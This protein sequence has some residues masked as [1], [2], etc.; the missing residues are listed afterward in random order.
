MKSLIAVAFVGVLMA[1]GFALF[2]LLRD[3]GKTNRTVYAL[4][5]RVALSVALLVFIWVSWHFGW[6]QPTQY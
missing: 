4:T 3:K 5:V 1:L 6:I 2:F